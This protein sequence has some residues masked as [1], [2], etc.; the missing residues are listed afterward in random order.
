[1]ADLIHL[2]QIAIGRSFSCGSFCLTADEIVSFAQRY[3]P[4]PFHTCEAAARA[5]A[6][7]GLVASSVQSFAE[8]ASLLVRAIADVDVIAGLGWSE[9]KLL[10]PIRPGLRYSVEGCWTSARRSATRESAGVAQVDGRVTEPSGE[11]VLTFGVIYLV[12]TALRTGGAA[13]SR[14]AART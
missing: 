9:T 3:D 13:S 14:A 2:E 5:S 12:R 8:A 6:F 10:G 4:Q 11:P 7:G 1:M